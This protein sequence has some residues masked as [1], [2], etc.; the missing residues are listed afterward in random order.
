[1]FLS[2]YTYLLGKD[3][4][5]MRE[6]GVVHRKQAWEKTRKSQVLKISVV[7]HFVPETTYSLHFASA[8]P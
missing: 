3:I 8:R 7:S 2:R 5:P 1:M 4:K 6:S